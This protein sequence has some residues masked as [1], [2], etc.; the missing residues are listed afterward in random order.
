MLALRKCQPCP[1]LDFKD[2]GNKMTIHDSI[3]WEKYWIKKSVE[4]SIFCISGTSLMGK[5]SSKSWEKQGS[6]CTAKTFS[7]NRWTAMWF[8]SAPKMTGQTKNPYF[9]PW[10]K[11]ML[12]KDL[13]A[14][15]SQ[16]VGNTLAF[17][18]SQYWLAKRESN[19]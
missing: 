13:S 3:F 1:A 10:V 19:S 14:R 2:V 11:V 7:C 9:N 6:H 5:A 12:D 17:L 4:R 8:V 16:L 15:F 18:I